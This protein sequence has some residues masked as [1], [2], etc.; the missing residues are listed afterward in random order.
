MSGFPATHCLGADAR[1]SPPQP[2]SDRCRSHATQTCWTD[3]DHHCRCP[4]LIERTDV[5]LVEV[6]ELP[7]NTAQLTPDCPAS[8]SPLPPEPVW[9][10]ARAGVNS[11]MEQP[12]AAI[13]AMRERGMTSF[14][15]GGWAFLSRTPN[16]EKSRLTPPVPGRVT[17]RQP[18]ASASHSA[19][20]V[21]SYFKASSDDGECPVS[22]R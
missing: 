12:S 14:S 11:A 15:S 9:A 8:R 21:N 16:P 17:G 5:A 18:R 4:R 7:R 1:R 6:S 22:R 19:A 10:L 3:A 13:A 2:P 20:K